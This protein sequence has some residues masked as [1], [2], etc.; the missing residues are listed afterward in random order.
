[1]R[2]ATDSN[3]DCINYI[4]EAN[5]NNKKLGH[6]CRKRRGSN[7]RIEFRDIFLSFLCQK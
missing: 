3:K 7:I 2:L 6:E 5:I 1:M 4:C